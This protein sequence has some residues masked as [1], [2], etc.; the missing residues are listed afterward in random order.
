MNE[1]YS[2]KVCDKCEIIANLV[3]SRYGPDTKKP[4]SLAESGA[5]Y[6]ELS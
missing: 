6:V 5:V 1:I 3:R 4:R 2:G